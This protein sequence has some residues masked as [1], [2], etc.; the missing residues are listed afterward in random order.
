[1]SIL[2]NS[3]VQAQ[4]SKIDEEDEIKEIDVTKKAPILNHPGKEID[5]TSE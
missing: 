1:M 4:V 5:I 3:E 2:A